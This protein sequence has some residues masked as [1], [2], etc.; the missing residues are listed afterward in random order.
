MALR[1]SDCKMITIE[2][3]DPR[4]DDIERNPKPIEEL[5]VEKVKLLGD[6]DHRLVRIGK[7]LSNH[8]RQKLVKFLKKYHEC[9]A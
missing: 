2:S 9:F 6:N 5:E 1:I 7:S 3:L 8:F 4:G